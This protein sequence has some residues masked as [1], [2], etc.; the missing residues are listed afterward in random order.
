VIWVYE[1]PN[2]GALVLRGPVSFFDKEEKSIKIE[3]Q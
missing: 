3:H 2:Q 1:N